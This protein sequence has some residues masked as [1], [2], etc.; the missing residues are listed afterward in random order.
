[1]EGN[2]SVGFKTLSARLGRV[3]EDAL[4]DKQKNALCLAAYAIAEND[5]VYQFEVSLIDFIRAGWRGD[6]L[7]TPGPS[8]AVPYLYLH[9]SRDVAEGNIRVKETTKCSACGK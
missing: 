4:M 5:F 3:Y 8:S 9:P 6:C 2:G 1:M 7:K